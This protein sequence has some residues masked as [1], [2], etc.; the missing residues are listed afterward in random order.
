MKKVD[1]KGLFWF[2]LL[3]FTSTCLVEFLMMARG[4]SFIGFPSKIGQFIVA[5]VM[6]FPGISAFIVRKYI[7]HEGFN[8]AG[9][10]LG[11]GKYYLQTHIIIPIFPC[12]HFSINMVYLNFLWRHFRSCWQYISPPL[13]LR[14]LSM[15]SLRLGKNSA[16]GDICCQSFFL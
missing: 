8:D 13:P 15:L 7:T 12:R 4:I 9:L 14:H 6:F 10:K 5:L 11:K 1:K 2:L 3:M 16:C